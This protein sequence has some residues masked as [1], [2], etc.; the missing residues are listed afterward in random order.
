M[1]GAL[2]VS[3]QYRLL[4]N[5]HIQ[6]RLRQ[7]FLIDSLLC[8][9]YLLFRPAELFRHSVKRLCHS[10]GARFLRLIN[11]LSQLCNTCYLSINVAHQIRVGDLNVFVGIA[12]RIKAL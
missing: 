3:L 4:R 7:C 2:I 10:C 12:H 11:L 8:K 6:L 9:G 1:P 5:L